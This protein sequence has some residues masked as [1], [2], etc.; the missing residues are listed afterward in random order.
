MQG[1]AEGVAEVAVF[2][3][4]D[5]YY[6]EIVAAAV[7]LTALT[8]AASLASFCE[9]RIARFKIPA[10]YY[11]VTAFPLTASGKIRKSALRELAGA[12]RLGVLS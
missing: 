5:S 11:E 2:G 12:G 8:S 6:G 7:K 3:L 4:P 10:R 1:R 9:G